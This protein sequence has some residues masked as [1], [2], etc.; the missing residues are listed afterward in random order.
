MP[1]FSMSDESL[2][3]HDDSCIGPN[4]INF[5]TGFKDGWDDACAKESPGRIHLGLYYFTFHV[6]EPRLL[7]SLS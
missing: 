6:L 5:E 7:Y 3:L 2:G 4:F 1:F